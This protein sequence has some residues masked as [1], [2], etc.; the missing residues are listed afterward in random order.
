MYA[1]P[2]ILPVKDTQL[3][4]RMAQLIAYDLFDHS[5]DGVFS[6]RTGNWS[7]LRLRLAGCSVEDS[8]SNGANHPAVKGVRE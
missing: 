7:R 1:M 3:I 4:A 6:S 8:N 2:H 5:V